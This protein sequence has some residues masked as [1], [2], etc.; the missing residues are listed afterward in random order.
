MTSIDQY[1]VPESTDECER[2]LDDASH[3]K[4]RRSFSYIQ[5]FLSLA[6]GSL[7]T[8]VIVEQ[9]HRANSFDDHPHTNNAVIDEFPLGF[10][11]NAANNG[12]HYTSLDE[13]TEYEP[14]VDLLIGS[15]CGG[16]PHLNYSDFSPLDFLR[17]QSMLF[18]GDSVDRYVVQFLCGHSF[19]SSA[20]APC[21]YSTNK[22]N[23]SFHHHL[24]PQLDRVAVVEK[25]NGLSV[26]HFPSLNLTITHAMT[27]GVLPEAYTARWP[28]DYDY[29]AGRNNFTFNYA[30]FV[31]EFILPFFS[32]N[33]S[34][35]VTNG[36]R[37]GIIP[38]PS[39]VTAQSAL[40]DL[41]L[42][43]ASNKAIESTIHQRWFSDLKSVLI[44]SIEATFPSADLL[45]MRT[46]PPANDYSK[47]VC[48]QMATM[49]R[50]AIRHSRRTNSTSRWR[51]WD[52]GAM[53]AECEGFLFDSHH[54]GPHVSHQ[55]L[56]M[57]LNDYKSQQS[58][59]S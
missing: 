24:Y 33:N 58:I 53:L 37:I 10:W 49:M 5:C 7:A 3:S 8:L 9:L 32:Y 52:T 39:I 55:L 20:P 56:N 47:L 13:S 2:L 29:T 50:S 35:F 59:E 14:L 1:S 31:S 6:V 38:M 42:L 19:I 25:L 48:L 17:N 22:L 43:R 16:Y 18:I 40:W 51:L 44:P 28:F 41:Q 4:P 21:M 45:Y 36:S 23:A 26:C 27:Y 11:T 54:Y 30:T 12:T 46:T 34:A 15:E 57:L